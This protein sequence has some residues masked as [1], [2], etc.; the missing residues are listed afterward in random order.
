M[1]E[2]GTSSQRETALPD[3]TAPDPP[4]RGTTHSTEDSVNQ[5]ST[6]LQVIHV[7]FSILEVS[8]LLYCCCRFVVKHSHKA[9]G[10]ETVVVA[11]ELK[12]Q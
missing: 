9:V 7:V 6:A 10:S 8:V 4:K 2:K 12:R 1:K 5:A 11:E 3:S